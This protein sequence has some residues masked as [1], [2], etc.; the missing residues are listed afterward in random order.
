MARVVGALLF[1]ILFLALHFSVKPMK[2]CALR[3]TEK[4]LLSRAASAVSARQH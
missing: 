2:R 3:Y 4:Q 1:S